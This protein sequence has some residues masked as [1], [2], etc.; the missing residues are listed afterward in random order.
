[1][2]KCKCETLLLPDV[3]VCGWS[4]V[5]EGALE[6][7][8]TEIETEWEWKSA[9]G[10]RWVKH[11]L[12]PPSAFQSIHNS[13]Y[14]LIQGPKKKPADLHEDFFLTAWGRM[15]CNYTNE[16]KQ[17]A[18][19]IQNTYI[20][21]IINLNRPLPIHNLVFPVSALVL[22]HELELVTTGRDP[23]RRSR[24]RNRRPWHKCGAGLYVRHLRAQ[25]KDRFKFYYKT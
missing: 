19:L 6:L 7:L 17:I 18:L 3:I 11:S 2:N 24:Y 20:N 22:V 10:S 16:W 15:L 21:T 8:T 25:N 12:K 13:L 4:E 23:S 14:A 1:M 5:S 9:C